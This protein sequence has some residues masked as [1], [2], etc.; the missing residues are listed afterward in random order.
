MCGKRRLAVVV[1]RVLNDEGQATAPLGCRAGGARIEQL[2][3][4]RCQ[5]HTPAIIARL[6]Q[7]SLGQQHYVDVMITDS[8]RFVDLPT[9]RALKGQRQSF[10]DR[11]SQFF[12]GTAMRMNG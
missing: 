11:V 10:F 9:D 5:V 6:A 3:A 4:R 12:N 1:E 7:P 2:V 8:E